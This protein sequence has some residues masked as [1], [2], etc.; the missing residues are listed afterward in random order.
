MNG[1]FAIVAH[2]GILLL[3]YRPWWEEGIVHGMTLRPLS[4]AGALFEESLAHLCRATDATLLAHP[5]QTHGDSFFDARSVDAVQARRASHGSLSRFGE[6]DALIAPTVQNM[7]GERVAYGIATADCVPIVMRGRSGW[8]LV[9]A[10]WRGLA[11]GIV[12]KVAHALGDMDEVAIFACAGGSTYEVGEEVLTAIGETA[13]YRSSPAGRV[14]L[15]TAETAKKQLLP[16]VTPDRIAV[17]GICTILDTRFHSHR[18]DGDVAGRSMTFV[19]SV[20]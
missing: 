7:P 13:V 11:N 17:S 15:D 14:L 8:A 16:F 3:V 20:P 12:S 18:R 6:F 5:K 1:S 9:H 2:S 4:F 10:G 19:C